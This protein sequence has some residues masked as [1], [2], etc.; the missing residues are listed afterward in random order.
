MFT[1]IRTERYSIG[2]I[3]SAGSKVYF[4]K[5][6]AVA[7]VILII[8]IPIN[9]IL[10]FIPF[11]SEGF[12]GLRWY[13]RSAQI[14]ELLVGIIATVAV[15]K[16]VECAINGEP[17]TYAEALKYSL[18]RWGRA[19]AVQ[20]LAGLIIFGMLLLL[21][22][23]GVIWAIYYTF[24][25]YVVAL[26]GINGKAALDYSKRLV[27][28]QWGR[29]FGIGLLINLLALL[30]AFIIGF[31]IAIPFAFFLGDYIIEILSSTVVDLV[32]GLFSV[33]W[34]VFFLNVDYLKAPDKVDVQVGV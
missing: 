11:E 31:V 12:E 3:L 16:I 9:I 27:R 29:V 24:A 32:T 10:S 21:I 6:G 8:Y 7:P 13:F 4:E 15:A 22:V 17:I 1:N 2:K 5:F 18:T 28:G 26:R 19:I 23:P 14:L 33:A 25:I 30:A 20:I 34:V